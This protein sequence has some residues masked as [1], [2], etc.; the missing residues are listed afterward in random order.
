MSTG[1]PQALVGWA[2]FTSFGS[3]ALAICAVLWVRF[4]NLRLFAALARMQSALS[5][6]E[7][8]ERLTPSKLAQLSDVQEALTRA[9]ELLAKVN[10]REIARAKRRSDDGTFE[11]ATAGSLKDQLRAKAGLRAGQPA[12]H[13]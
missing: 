7:R 2:I 13:S 3:I 5:D 6:M 8:T 4:Q 11:S 12:L 9:E 1:Y 10:R